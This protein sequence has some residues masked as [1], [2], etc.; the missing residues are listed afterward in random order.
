[1]ET[2]YI[3]K[4]HRPKLVEER[5]NIGN[6]E[7]ITIDYNGWGTPTSATWTVE[8]GQATIGGQALASNVA[9]ANITVSEEGKSLIK[10]VTTDGTN[11]VTLFLKLKAIDETKV[12]DYGLCDYY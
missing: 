6:V 7:A 11:T 1:M 2:I 8:D 12:Y 5:L 10:I 3:V 9:T 4:N